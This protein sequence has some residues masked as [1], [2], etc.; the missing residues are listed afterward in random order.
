MKLNT[1]LI[2]IS[3]IISALFTYLFSNYARPEVIPLIC[4]GT[5]LGFFCCFGGLLG[6]SFDYDRTT[7]L[8]KTVSSIFLLPTLI[9][10][11]I[12]LKGIL[13][14]PIYIFLFSSAIL[15]QLLLIYSI[16]KSKH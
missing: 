10:N 4:A 12:F 8:T 7:F 13:D 6:L 11:L 2:F 16:S 1:F 3:I 5:F 15:L 9:I 14:A